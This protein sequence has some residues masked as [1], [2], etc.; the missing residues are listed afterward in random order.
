MGD[1]LDQCRGAT[2]RVTPFFLDRARAIASDVCIDSLHLVSL[3]VGAACL[4][5]K[6]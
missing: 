2:I 3:F 4:E 6:V 1:I 5:S